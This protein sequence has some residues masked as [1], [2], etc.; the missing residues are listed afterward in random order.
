MR[1]GDALFSAPSRKDFDREL[2]PRGRKQVTATSNYIHKIN[3]SQVFCSEATRTRQSFSILNEAGEFPNI[4]YSHD[5]YLSPLAI[6]LKFIWEINGGTDILLVGHNF[7]ISE[8][9]NYFS[10][11]LIEMSTAEYICIEFNCDN[12]T[13]TSR[14]TGTIIDRFYP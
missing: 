12:W 8:L 13:E 4:T 11:D 1:H 10:D 5:L 9:A 3:V 7:G 14:G 2:S 6:Y